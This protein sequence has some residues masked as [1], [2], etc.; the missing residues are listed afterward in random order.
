MYWTDDTSLCVQLLLDT[1]V[2]YR[3]VTSLSSLEQIMKGPGGMTEQLWSRCG[4][5]ETKLICYN[6]SNFWLI[7]SLNFK[8]YW[9]QL[10]R[11]YGMSKAHQASMPVVKPG[12]GK[13]CSVRW[14]S[15]AHRL[16]LSE[17]EEAAELFYPSAYPE[18]KKIN[19]CIYNFFWKSGTKQ[20]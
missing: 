4:R 17:S 13:Y 15:M 11:F 3:S 8:S 18:K 10:S 19:F 12:L 16:P 14:I 20:D 5:V 7:N 6:T 9:Q 2:T 1:A